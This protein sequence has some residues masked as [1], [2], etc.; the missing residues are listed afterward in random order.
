MPETGTFLSRDPFEGIPYNPSTVNGYKY[1]NQNPINL[2]D[3][4]GFSPLAGNPF[5]ACMQMPVCWQFLTA[6][7]GTAIAISSP[8]AVVVGVFIAVPAGMIYICTRFDCSPQ[9]S[10]PVVPAPQAQDYYNP[11]QTAVDEMVDIAN[12]AWDNW[13]EP[14][15]EPAPTA[16]IDPVPPIP[17]ATCTP[18]PNEKHISLGFTIV[19]GRPT[20]RQFT[21]LLNDHLNP[22]RKYV[23]GQWEDN[24]TGVPAN[25]FSKAIE[26][27]F[28]AVRSGKV[29]EIHFNL[30]GIKERKG[31]DLNDPYIDFA[32]RFGSKGDIDA[33]NSRVF[34]QGGVK[35]PFI[36]ADELYLV[37]HDA[38]LCGKTTFYEKG[39]TGLS[40]Y[41]GRICN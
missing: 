6:T 16:L 29:T 40:S 25:R 21:K 7:G 34:E 32:E 11:P 41:A 17:P 35:P 15:P 3:P 8:P 38:L 27:V 36:T 5:T 28:N 12:Q 31:V 23:F 1:A 26:A 22:Q 2:T 33:T 30:E 13:T 24:I 4:S 9:S 37:R 18:E 39:S 14:E 19:N 20:L 10:M